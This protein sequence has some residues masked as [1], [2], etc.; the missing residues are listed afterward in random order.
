MQD[1]GQDNVEDGSED[2]YRRTHHGHRRHHPKTAWGRVAA[3]L[4]RL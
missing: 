1:Q 4:S 3:W 2:S